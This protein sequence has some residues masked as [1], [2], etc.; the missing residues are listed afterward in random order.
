MDAEVVFG[1]LLGVLVAGRVFGR[2]VSRAGIALV[3]LGLGLS[4]LW[5]MLDGVL[6]F[7]LGYDWSERPI[8]ALVSRELRLS[9]QLIALLGVAIAAFTSGPT[10]KASA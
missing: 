5:S 9:F 3:V 1:L 4:L 2:D 10:A 8:S 6:A 7:A